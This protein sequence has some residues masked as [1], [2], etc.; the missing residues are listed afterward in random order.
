VPLTLETNTL[1]GES[2]EPLRCGNRRVCEHCIPMEFHTE[3]TLI[4]FEASPI[5]KNSPTQ[6][7]VVPKMAY[8]SSAIDDLTWG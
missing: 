8:K 5:V 7:A 1:D 3:K 6:R 4:Q 2:I